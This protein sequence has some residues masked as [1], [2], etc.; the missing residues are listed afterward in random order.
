MTRVWIGTG[1]PTTPLYGDVNG[2]GQINLD[3]LT[4]LTRMVAGLS[5]SNSAQLT[6]ADVFP[7]AANDPVKHLPGDKKLTIVDAM[8]L[9]RFI[10]GGSIT[11][12]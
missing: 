9:T 7:P 4:I 12:P 11:W 2:D 6:R 1:T 10:R 3:D 8:R 5:P